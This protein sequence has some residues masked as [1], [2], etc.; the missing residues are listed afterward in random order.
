M[1]LTLKAKSARR[2]VL[3]VFQWNSRYNGVGDFM[4]ISKRLQKVAE[5]VPTGSS[6]ADIGSDHAYLPVY[7]AETGIVTRAVAGEVNPG[8]YDTAKRRVSEAGLSDLITVRKGDGLQ[9]LERGEADVITIAGM[10]GGTIVDILSSGKGKLTEVKRLILQPMADSD[11]LRKWLHQNNWKIISEEIVFEDQILYEIVISEPGIETYD[12]IL[13]YEIGSV[14]LLKKH[15]LFSDKV[16]L[17][18]DRTD[19]IIQNLKRAHGDEAKQ[20]L[21]ELLHKKKRLGEVLQNVTN[22]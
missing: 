17:M 4:K 19:R 14:E 16:Q 7:L 18:I 9:V 22:R 21:A 2:G 13:W 8:P 15:P 11:R 12:D 6:L 5:Y 3:F 20:K 1:R 10:G